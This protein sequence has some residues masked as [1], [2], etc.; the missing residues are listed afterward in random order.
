MKK[1]FTLFTAASG[2]SPELLAVAAFVLLATL[3]R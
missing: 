3:I 1:L 2:I